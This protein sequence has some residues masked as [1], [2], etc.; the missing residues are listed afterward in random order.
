M[1]K[2]IIKGID[3]MK[4]NVINEGK[5]EDNINFLKDCDVEDKYDNVILFQEENFVFIF[6]IFWNISNII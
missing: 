4:G 1:Y 6:E 2:I 3:K 5:E